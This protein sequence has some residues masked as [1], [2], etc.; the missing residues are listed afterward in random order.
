VLD[1][2]FALAE[3]LLKEMAEQ[4][5][6]REYLRGRAMRAQW[7]RLSPLPRTR[8][9]NSD[10]SADA[11]AED[12]ALSAPQAPCARGG[13]AMCIDPASLQIYLL[14]G[15][16]GTHTLSDFWVYSVAS[17]EW[18]L[19]SDDTEK[20]KNGPGKRCCH[21]MV[22]D[23]KGGCIYLLGRLGDGAETAAIG[24]ENLSAGPSCESGMP[25]VAPPVTGHDNGQKTWAYC[26]EFH[27]YHTRGLDAGKWDLLS[28]DTAVRFPRVSG[29]QST[30]DPPPSI[31]ETVS[32]RATA[33]L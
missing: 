31:N 13:H 4:G 12:S 27:R 28:F 9:A 14:G 32:R 30:A 1:G 33:H 10:S 11:S 26:S 16:T 18:T 15:Y 23:E 5:M 6:F 8:A 24:G 3:D 7:Q 2:D 21:K 20:E 22:W 17:S 25:G 29:T 19:L